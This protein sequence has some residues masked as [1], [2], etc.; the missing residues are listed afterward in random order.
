MFVLAI[1]LEVKPENIEAFKDVASANA[2]ATLT[3]PGAL[4]FDLLQQ[5]D[6]PTKFMFYEVYR[7]EE[8]F[9]A[10]QQTAHYKRWVEKG[11]PLLT[12]ERVRAKYTNV[13]PGDENWH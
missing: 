5:T 9:K 10:H 13:E 4:R 2:R 1:Y 7:S 3:E 12:G 11:V 6:E 8:A